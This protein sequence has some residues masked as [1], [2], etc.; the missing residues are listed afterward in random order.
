MAKLCES[1]GIH[2]AGE[3]A[4]TTITSAIGRLLPAAAVL[5]CSRATSERL[6]AEN[7]GSLLRLLLSLFPIL[8]NMRAWP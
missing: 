5:I 3:D 1:N 7:G 2:E 4:I 6:L 8:L